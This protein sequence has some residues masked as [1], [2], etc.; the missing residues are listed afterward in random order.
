MASRTRNKIIQGTAELLIRE[1]FTFIS[2]D[3]ISAYL[4]ISKKTLY[5]HFENKFTIYQEAFQ[6]DVQNLATTMQNALDESTLPMDDKIKMLILKIYEEFDK[7]SKILAEVSLGKIPLQI[8]EQYR[9]KLNEVIYSFVDIIVKE[10]IALNIIRTDIP[11]E[12]ISHIFLMMIQSIFFYTNMPEN[13][14][15]MELFLNSMQVL[16]DGSGKKNSIIA[17]ELLC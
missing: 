1:G 3:S 10:S 5:N 14:N 2:V 17:K 6:W 11:S 7:R 16:L 4:K 13:I 15:K 9:A 8:L 12:T